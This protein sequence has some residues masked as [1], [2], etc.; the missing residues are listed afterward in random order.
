MSPQDSR[1]V[2]DVQNLLRAALSDRYDLQR[3]VGRGGMAT[4]YLA[5]D[6][7]HRRSVAVKIF[8]PA[9]AE[10][11]GPERFQREVQ[12]AAQLSHP[13]I[14]TLF[15]SGE[16]DGLL[17]YVMPFVSG[18]SLRARLLREPQ[19]PVD[20]ALRITRNVASALSYAHDHDVVH[21]DIK[22]E[23][24]ML[25][26]GEAMVTDFGIA[27]ALTAA[28][29]E[30]LTQTGFIVGT[31]T[32]MSPEQAAGEAVD[33]RSDVYSLACVLFEMLCGE[34]PFG[35]APLVSLARRLA[36]PPPSAR[37]RR[38]QVSEA[39]DNVIAGGLTRTRE[40]RYTAAEFFTALS[41]PGPDP[42]AESAAPTAAAA[43]G[44]GTGSI[45]VLPF[46]NL[47]PD[48][49]TEYFSDGMTDELISALTR[50][51]GL[52]V[53]SR[54][55]AFAFKGKPQDVRT[56]G[57]QLNVRTALEGSVRKA[58]RR[59]RVTA[60][61]TDVSSGYQIWSEV[62]DRDLE[63]VFAIQE[64]IS[65]AIVSALRGKLLGPETT[66]LVRPATDD[67]E[68]YT[69]YL[70][71]RQLWNR[72][73]EESLRLGLQ[74]FERA[75]ERDPRYGMA[76]IGV[77]DSYSILGFY[78][79]LRPTEAFPKA[80][81]AALRALELD[82]RLSEARPTLAYVSMYHDWD[83]TGAERQFRMAISGN[84]GYATAHQWYGN[85]LAVL[86]R[87]DES[88][89][90]FGKA[91]ALDPLSALKGAA[92]GWSY[93]FARRYPEAIAQCRRALELDPHLAVTHL[94]LGLASQETGANDEA[95][96]AYEEGVRL[97]RGEPLGLSFLAHGLAR[98]GRR[99]E[100][101]RKLRELQDLSARHY[102]SSYDLAVICAGLGDREGAL[103]LL[104]KGYQERTHWMALLQVDPRLDP[105]RDSPRF[106]R[107]LDSMGFPK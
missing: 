58:S 14:L 11:L 35:G 94:W 100:A 84:P 7:K 10:T 62:F 22:P 31:P 38:D 36:E 41:E 65:R 37:A 60:Q 68:A 15:D 99:D 24:V 90:E 25:Y 88:T 48:P 8:H 96:K 23:N 72:R 13:H 59:L 75:L 104:E 45:V 51:E 29:G 46:V 43:S 39:L 50:V 92:L 5:Q 49:D 64:E 63:D 70:K 106:R 69:L 34:P 17:Y 89:T 30:T 56:I 19:L 95:V 101:Q 85:F 105:L 80:K 57:A 20:E 18:E 6:L 74:H 26:E 52:H 102:V 12:I 97:S 91:I 3:E 93:Y 44:L 82:P 66:R 103:D 98:A 54:T 40:G 1:S 71:G 9:L 27:K 76:H 79:A 16:A 28:G 2:P 81:A 83:W 32:Y 21:R 61:L 33:G 87:F 78:T 73:T 67:L 4:V 86:R 77:A 55:S 42:R 47:S 53:V 107:V